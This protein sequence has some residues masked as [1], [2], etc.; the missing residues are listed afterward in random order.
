MAAGAVG[1]WL[2]TVSRDGAEAVASAASGWYLLLA[3]AVPA[4]TWLLVRNDAS[5]P[6][7][8]YRTLGSTLTTVVAGLVAATL[9]FV[10]VATQVTQLFGG[11]DGPAV[12]EEL[13]A[14]LGW[15]RIGIV[16]LASIV[17]AIALRP[18]RD[19]ASG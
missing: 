18:T 4:G 1:G 16:A 19:S 6:A 2:A 11:E 7:P 8:R 3:L 14:A 9:L 13:F 12:A 15:W 5:R 17:T 10:A